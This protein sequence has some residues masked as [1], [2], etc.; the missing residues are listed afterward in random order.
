[1]R[2][3]GTV[4]AKVGKP[5]GVLLENEAL[6]RKVHVIAPLELVVI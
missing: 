3:L 1:M 6:A 5:R 4:T 2:H